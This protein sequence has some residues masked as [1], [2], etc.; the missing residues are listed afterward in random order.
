MQ[1]PAMSSHQHLLE[2]GRTDYL[3]GLLR[4]SVPLLDH[5]GWHLTDLEEGYCR[6][7]LPAI[8]ATTNQHH[9]LQASTHLLS[10]DYTGGI[11]LGTLFY[12]MPTF[13][14]HP[15]DGGWGNNLWLS[16]AD[17]KYVAAAYGD[18]VVS[19]R[20]EDGR[21]EML[22]RRF[23]RGQRVVAQVVLAFS[24][25]G[26]TTTKGTTTYFA[27]KTRYEDWRAMLNDSAAPGRAQAEAVPRPLFA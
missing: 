16:H 8:P 4:K 20:I 7:V 21:R 26:R 23:W 25:N 14:V 9:A 13:G 18:L 1:A 15:V 3:T 2:F 10:A 6:A 5:A 11:A 19:C 17:L 12:G 27:Q 22:Q 24:A